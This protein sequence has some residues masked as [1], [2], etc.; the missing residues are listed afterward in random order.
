MKG[1]KNVT[2]IY[3]TPGPGSCPDY[4]F[5]GAQFGVQFFLA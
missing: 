4:P 3:P 5:N 2:G 1:L